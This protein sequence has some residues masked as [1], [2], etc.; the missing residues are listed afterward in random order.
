LIIDAKTKKEE[1]YSNS[2]PINQNLFETLLNKYMPQDYIL[3]KEEIQRYLEKIIKNNTYDDLV[4][5]FE[6]DN[7]LNNSDF[8]KTISDALKK[9]GFFNFLNKCFFHYC[10]FN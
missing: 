5:V 1:L 4:T 2:V 7:Y 6:V 9:K 10:Y 3:N 8:E